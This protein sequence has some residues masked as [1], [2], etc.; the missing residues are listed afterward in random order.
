[1]VYQNCRI[2]PGCRDAPW[3]V[4]GVGWSVC[5]CFV[6]RSTERPYCEVFAGSE[7]FAE[8]G[9]GVG[10]LRGASGEQGGRSAVVLSDALRSVP[11]EK[12]C[13][14]KRMSKAIR[15]LTLTHSPLSPAVRT[16][17]E[18]A[19]PCVTG[20]YSNRLNYRTSLLLP[21]YLRSRLL[22]LELSLCS[23]EHRWFP[24]RLR[25][26]S[27][28]AFLILPNFFATLLEKNDFF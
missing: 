14:K 10:T 5:G 25:V 9:Q 23:F 6:G 13:Y 16:R 24:C 1:M 12:I 4:R 19:T 20:R 18:L 3:S 26:Q 7:V 21:G 17:L 8:S 11:T 28:K 15:R 22:S 2:R 27:Y